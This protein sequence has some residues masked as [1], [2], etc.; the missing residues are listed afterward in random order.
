MSVSKA[1]YTRR[2]KQLMGMMEPNSIAILP[3]AYEK[4]R[5]RDTDFPFRQDSDFMY[6]TGFSEPEAVLALVP[7]REHGEVVWFCREKDKT[8]EIWDGYRA[9]P[10]G[11]CKSYGADDAF[12]IA[13][14][15]DILPGLLEGRERV[16]YA[17][18]KDPE[19]DKH[20]MSWVNSIRAKVRSGASPPG[21]FLDLDHFLH[22]MRLY[23]S[24]GEIRIMAQAANISAE[25]HALAMQVCK[26]GIFEYQLESEIKH[27]CAMKGG[28]HQAYNAIVGGGN[29]ACI[30]HYVENSEKLKDGDL[31]LIDAGCEYQG[32]A[33]DITRT[34][35]VNGK[36]S[37][38]QKAIYEL[39]LSAQNAALEK[40]QAGNHW[41]EPHDASVRTITTGLVE[42]GLLSGDVDALIENEAFKEFYMHRIGHWI[43]MDV[44]DVGDYKVG[45]EW[46]VLEVGMVMTVEPGIY[47]SPDNEN[48][49]A[50]WRGIGVRI[51]DDVLVDKEGARIF[52]HA[53]PKSV[54]DIEAL[55]SS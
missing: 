40:I 10:E 11:V 28:R 44:H 47:I 29:N 22:D 45:G 8:K 18:G 24:A 30:L 5:S 4:S 2:R 19:F 39:V 55:M 53:A 42:L 14:I 23:K 35:P 25:A 7:G 48:V 26:P 41:N 33:S 34:F 16:Y 15:D 50:K 9:G 38:E 36:F 52:S 6:L 51:E 46:R 43:G 17:L 27:A 54:A 20:V 32:Y 13:D 1:E 12:P 37:K 31:V 3:S 49:A 21:E